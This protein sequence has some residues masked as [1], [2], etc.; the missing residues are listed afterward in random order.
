MSHAG[1][2]IDQYSAQAAQQQRTKKPAFFDLSTNKGA[3]RMSGLAGSLGGLAFWVVIERTLLPNNDMLTKALA[4]AI[5]LLLQFGTNAFVSFLV[6]WTPAGMLLLSVQ[7]KTKGQA[8]VVLVAAFLLVVSYRTM[9]A[10]WLGQKSAEG[11]E[12]Q[13]TLVG[14]IGFSIV[15]ALLWT[16]V[17]DQELVETIRQAHLVKRYELQSTAD[18][19]I[20]R[21]TLIRAQNKTKKGWANLTDNERA[22]LGAVMRSLVSGIDG[23]LAEIYATVKTVSGGEI[24]VPRLGDQDAM[25]DVLDYLTERMEE[26][27]PGPDAPIHAEVRAAMEH[28]HPRQLEA[29]RAAT[30]PTAPHPTVIEA[31]AQTVQAAK[32][33]TAV[34]ASPKQVAVGQGLK[35]ITGRLNRGKE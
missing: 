6:P 30:G 2:L 12:M 25:V 9:M 21:A 34:Q 20:L 28:L 19:A 1:G 33:A 18:I 16:P 29:P 5:A 35:S 26:V 14:L 24:A 4:V 22:E 31:L 27:G 11:L 7:S 3:L 17:G 23:T 15:P 10:F 13:Q 8:V 32:P